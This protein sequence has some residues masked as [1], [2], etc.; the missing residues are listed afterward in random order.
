MKIGGIADIARLPCDQDLDFCRSLA[1]ASVSSAPALR[2]PRLCICQVSS[3]FLRDDFTSKRNFSIHFFGNH[4]VLH[5]SDQGPSRQQHSPDRVHANQPAII[6]PI[7][8]MIL[9][10][11][12]CAENGHPQYGRPEE[13]RNQH[14]VAKTKMMAP[15]LVPYAAD[16]NPAIDSRA[17]E[18][19]RRSPTGRLSFFS[20]DSEEEQVRTSQRR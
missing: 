11:H 1:A 9:L 10:G 15:A 2:H 19:T 7:P 4:I 13:G 14:S 3:A 16:H 18:H 5:L 8:P 17:A 12:C 6:M 20:M